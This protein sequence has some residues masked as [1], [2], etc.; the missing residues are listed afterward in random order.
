MREHG[1]STANSPLEMT[2]CKWLIPVIGNI[3][4]AFGLT[5]LMDRCLPRVYVRVP[6]KVQ[7]EALRP[8]SK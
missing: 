8:L 2:S 3:V 4:A 1:S 6:S 5:T 7:D